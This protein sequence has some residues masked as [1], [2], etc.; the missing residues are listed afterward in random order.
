MKKASAKKPVD[1]LRPEYDLSKLKGGVHGKY[2]DQAAA[3]TNLIL[4]EPDLA[5][6][7]PDAGSVNRALRLLVDT[8]SA[9][10]T[11][12]QR[13]GSLIK[14]RPKSGRV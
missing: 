9:A 7:F 1:Q 4:I 2:L 10:A 11:P 13:T 3:G 8:A 14:R 12:R 5:E 6:V